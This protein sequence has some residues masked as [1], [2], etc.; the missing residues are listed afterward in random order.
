MRKQKRTDERGGDKAQTDRQTDFRRHKNTRES[1]V[2]K[3]LSL[4]LFCVCSFFRCALSFNTY[5]VLFFKDLNMKP[6]TSPKSDF[7]CTTRIIAFLKSTSSTTEE[8]EDKEEDK[9]EE[10][11]EASIKEGNNDASPDARARI[12]MFFFAEA[13]NE[14]KKRRCTHC[15]SPPLK[16]LCGWSTL[17][18]EC[19]KTE[20]PLT[21]QKKTTNH[22]LELV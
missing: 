18:K 14:K 2:F 3:P 5:P 20:P 4:S 6:Y 19:L 21:S 10:D 11:K 12:C 9:E 7:V 15:V 13:D 22:S 1:R 8:E 17:T 16:K